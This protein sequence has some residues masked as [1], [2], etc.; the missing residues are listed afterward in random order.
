VS[1]R[2]QCPARGT[3][4]V[5]RDR[6]WSARSHARRK[7]CGTGRR[8][9]LVIFAAP[10][11]AAPVVRALWRHLHRLKPN[12]R[13]PSI[14]A[15]MY[16]LLIHYRHKCR[17]THVAQAY[18]CERRRC[19]GSVN[20]EGGQCMSDYRKGYVQWQG[21]DYRV[22]WHPISKESMFIGALTSTLVRRTTCNKLLTL[23][24][25]G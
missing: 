11:H 19:V 2:A 22:T 15:R 17:S 5:Q 20:E 4:G 25:R 1:P 24:Y 13:L 12:C 16:N 6:T 14:A 9:R 21:Q 23:Q 3:R 7:G 10:Q 18:M 8:Q